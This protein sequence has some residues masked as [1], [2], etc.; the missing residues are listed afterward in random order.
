M[1]KTLPA[2]PFPWQVLLKLV[3]TAGVLAL[4]VRFVPLESIWDGMQRLSPLVWLAVLA[5]FILGHLVNAL[6][7]YLLIGRGL[8][9]GTVAKAHFAGLASNLV[10]PGTSGGDVTRAALLTREHGALSELVTGSI[11]D[12]LIDV[13]ILV[14]LAA[15]AASLL[16]STGDTGRA[17]QFSALLLIALGGLTYLALPVLDRWLKG[18]FTSAAPSRVIKLVLEISDFLTR[19]RNRILV[20]AALSGAIQ[21]GFVALNAMLS[22]NMGGPT[23][24]W[25]WMF[26]WPLAKLIATLPISLGGLGVR[27]ASLASIFAGLGFAAPVVVAVGLV[28]QTIVLGG[29]LF[30]LAVQFVSR[31]SRDEKLSE[32]N[33]RTN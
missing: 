12:R 26:A 25:V 1:D 11:V 30:G 9:F 8:R 13:S 6:K 24:I 4:I 23:N 32:S 14:L 17:L 10:L 29:G 16:A 33:V 27:E 19:H 31:G 3:V 18:K 2:K 5:A 7:W 28:W 20:C 22:A 21:F 15:I